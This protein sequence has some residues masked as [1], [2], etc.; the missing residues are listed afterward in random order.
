VVR[1]SGDIAMAQKPATAGVTASVP[2]VTMTSACPVRTALNA[3]RWHA[4]RKH[5]PKPVTLALQA[6][7][8]ETR[9]EAMLAIIIE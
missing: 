4:R 2:P 7:M 9:P 5:R 3:C 1:D 6:E 8:M